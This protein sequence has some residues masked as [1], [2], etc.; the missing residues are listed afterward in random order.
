[1]RQCHFREGVTLAIEDVQL[2]GR[3]CLRLL[4]RRAR[5]LTSKPAK[6]SGLTSASTHPRL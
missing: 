2:A 6:V 4:T 5:R 3:L 1:M